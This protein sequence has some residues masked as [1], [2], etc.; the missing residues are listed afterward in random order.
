MKYMLDTN[1]CI[2]IIKKQPDSVLQKFIT[3]AQDEVCISSV[4]LAEMMYGVHKSQHPQKNQYALAEFIFPLEVMPFNE[5]ATAHYGEIRAYLEKKGI[6]IG[7]L[8]TMI[9]AHARCLNA[10]LVTNNKKEFVRIPD[11][12]IQD[13]VHKH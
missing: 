7:P 5:A 1:I 6:P 13:W 10:I 4:T 8:D 9:A 11:L 3:L 12:E 2:Y